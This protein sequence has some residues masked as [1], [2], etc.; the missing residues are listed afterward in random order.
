MEKLCFPRDTVIRALSIAQPYA[1]L[2]FHGKIETRSWNTNYRGLVLICSTQKPCRDL[3]QFSGR[4]Q[5][6]QIHQLLDDDTFT[7]LHGFALGIG[8]LYDVTPMQKEDRQKAFAE[9]SPRLYCHHYRNVIRIEPFPIKGSQR[10]VILDP[11]TLDIRPYTKSA[12]LAVGP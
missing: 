6:E 5:I 4:D 11:A 3:F 12:S 2:M 1:T 8:E 9:Y 7:D 10:W